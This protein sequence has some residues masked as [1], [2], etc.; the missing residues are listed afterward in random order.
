MAD[1]YTPVY[2]LA[3]KGVITTEANRR[4][5]SLTM[6][7]GEVLN[8]LE[9]MVI[10]DPF[11]KQKTVQGSTTYAWPVTGIVHAAYHK[12]GEEIVGQSAAQQTQITI[13]ADDILYSDLFFPSVY[14]AFEHFDVVREYAQKAAYA[15][16]Q[17]K[18]VAQ[19]VTVLKAARSA[20]HLPGI[21]NGGAQ[22]VTDSFKVATGGAADTA[23]ACLA[24]IEAL[25]AG[26]QVMDE[27]NIPRAGRQALFRPN[28]YYTLLRGIQSNGF[29][30]ANKD[31][32]V[33]PANLNE[34]IVPRIA[35]FEVRMSNLLPKTNLTATGDTL[36]GTPLTHAAVPVH[37]NH[38]A[39][40]TK[41]MGMLWHPEAT[42]T[43]TWMG[44]QTRSEYVHERFGDLLLTW[45]LLGHGVLRP[46]CA[47]ELSL[48]SLT[49]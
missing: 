31:F 9:N 29:S 11:V 45:L 41:T 15:I 43:L 12:A 7:A 22:I 14:K 33:S 49:A 2:G 27:K 13:T 23:E 48:D 47:I 38:T 20:A 25:F 35:G 28:E 26:A 4:A 30:L 34:G 39:D 5:L 17:S 37:T 16:A 21:T 46:E 42:G 10:M 8:A 1:A 3:D 24:L 6:F 32:M 40:C 19:M 18:D 36:G 44:L